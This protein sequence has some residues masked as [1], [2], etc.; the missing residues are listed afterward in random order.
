MSTTSHSWPAWRYPYMR[1][2]LP[3][4]WST[5]LK[6]SSWL[7]LEDR[8]VWLKSLGK[9]SSI[10]QLDIASWTESFDGLPIADIVLN[11]EALKSNTETTHWT[12]TSGSR[13]EIIHLETVITGPKRNKA[14]FINKEWQIDKD[15]WLPTARILAVYSKTAHSQNSIYLSKQK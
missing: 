12:Y 11:S 13:D 2:R 3:S 9:P 14:E 5:H 7:L 10:E 15:D 4:A 1:W 6:D 8:L